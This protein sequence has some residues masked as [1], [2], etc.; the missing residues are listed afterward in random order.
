MFYKLRQYQADVENRIRIALRNGYRAPLLVMPTGS[1]KTV[2][3]SSVATQAAARGNRT[4]VVVHRSYLWRQVSKKLDEAGAPHGIIAPGHTQTADKIQVASVDTIIRRLDRVPPPGMI[5]FDEAHHVI[6]KNKWGKVANF[7]SDALILGVT[8]TPC[9]TSGRGLGVNA[10]GFFDTI[11]EGPQI[12]DLTPEYLSPYKLYAPDIG[13]DLTGVRRIAGDYEKGE[14]I[15]RVDKKRIYGAVPAHYRKLCYG[16]PAIAFC[17]SVQHAER[18]ADEFSASG[19]PAAAVSGKTPENV[20]TQL[21][22]G[23]ASGKYMVLCSCDLVSEGFDVPVCGCAI[24]LRPTQSLTL[25]LQQWGRAGRISPGKKYAYI[26]DHVGNYL[27]HG[28]P[29]AR[30]HWTLDG[31]KW[32]KKQYGESVINIRTCPKCFNVHAPAPVCPECG[33]VYVNW[34]ELPKTVE[35]VLKEV[36]TDRERQE[37]NVKIARRQEVGRADSLEALQE[38][39]RQR[40]YKPKWAQIMW[41]IKQGRRRVVAPINMKYAQ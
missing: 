36:Q 32:S 9:R 39:A 28:M 41:N 3:F 16:I 1:G 27:R 23:L 37:N 38:I 26:L 6:N 22:E 14:L 13:I 2:V 12:L 18:V 19:I 15:K 33:H 30:R 21:F 25:C 40:G 11:I 29:D 8:A 24:G 5:I 17:V 10:G 7:F 4:L 34:R 31:V 35:A 20:R